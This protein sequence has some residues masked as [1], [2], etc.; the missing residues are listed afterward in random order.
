MYTPHKAN[1]ENIHYLIHL[2]YLIDLSL[3]F[4]IHKIKNP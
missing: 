3:F 2:Q 4:K 1:Y